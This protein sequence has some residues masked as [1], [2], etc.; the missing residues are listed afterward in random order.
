LPAAYPVRPADQDVSGVGGLDRISADGR[1]VSVRFISG[2]CI[3]GWGAR[4]YQTSTAVVVGS[5]VSGNSAGSG[6]CA[7]VGVMRAATVR[8]QR[9]LG[10]RV[11][12]D[13]AT[14]QPLA[15]GGPMRM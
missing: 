11:V 4:A 1:T 7:A 14:G 9:A 8:L 13:V 2:A 12:L 5:W 15:L 10:L 3:T 6:A